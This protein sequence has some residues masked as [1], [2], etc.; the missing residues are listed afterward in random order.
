MQ[1]FVVVSRLSLVLFCEGVGQDSLSLPVLDRVLSSCLTQVGLPVLAIGGGILWFRSQVLEATCPVCAAPVTL[2]KN[3]V[4]FPLF[5]SLPRSPC[6]LSL[7]EA[8]S[9]PVEVSCVCGSAV[10]QGEDGRR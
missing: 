8:Q 10:Q 9:L 1:S 7:L 4:P 3:Q 6:S 5:P 2:V